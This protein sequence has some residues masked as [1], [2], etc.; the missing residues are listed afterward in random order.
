MIGTVIHASRSVTQRD[1]RIVR[2]GLIAHMAN[3]AGADGRTVWPAHSRASAIYV[4]SG[5]D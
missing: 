3:D 4:G 1:L 2:F 5:L